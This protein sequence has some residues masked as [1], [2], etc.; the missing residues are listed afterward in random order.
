MK[1]LKSYQDYNEDIILE[2]ISK[3]F[4]SKGELPFLISNELAEVLDNIR[5]PI[6]NKLFNVSRKMYS[7]VKK[8]TLLDI[9]LDEP[10]KFYFITSNRIMNE[11]NFENRDI[12][13]LY[14]YL[15]NNADDLRDKY[16]SKIRIGRLINKLFPDEFKP[17]G[18]PGKD[19]ESFVNAYSTEMVRNYE[20]F[21]EVDGEAINHW[22]D[23]DNY[24]IDD[25]ETIL[26]QSCMKHNYINHLISFYAINKNV[27]LII[28][29]SQD[30]DTEIDGRALLW[31]IDKIDNKDVK[32]VYFMDRIYENRQ[33]HRNK[34]IAYAKK[35]GYM[36]KFIQNSKDNELTSNIKDGQSTRLIIM[37]INNIDYPDHLEFPF[38]DTLIYYNPFDKILTNNIKDRNDKDKF[39]ELYDTE[40]YSRIKFSDKYNEIF[41]TG[42]K[43]WIEESYTGNWIKE[44]DAVYIYYENAWVNKDNIEEN[45][46]KSKYHNSY[47]KKDSAI[48]VDNYDD[49]INESDLKSDYRWKYNNFLDEWLKA[50]D[51]IYSDRLDTYIKKDNHI[52]IYKDHRKD[53][54]IVSIQDDPMEDYYEYKGD[55]YLEDVQKENID[56]YNENN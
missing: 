41:I 15:K 46:V 31:K 27:K 4:I 38:L 43:G 23:C 34:F 18:D 30:D 36:Y 26:N 5:H 29:K 10:D 17:N 9:V 20:L 47:I 33:V 50:A 53:S 14:N 19:I 35:K 49:W 24:N 42:T 3:E 12:E 11:P 13:Y 22:Y 16:K 21:K 8:Q 44:E 55:Y 56:R 25:S 52:K 40:G 6:A 45:Y 2:S 54:Y 7:E 51:A 39:A 37:E 32:D 28:L 1:I 48:Y